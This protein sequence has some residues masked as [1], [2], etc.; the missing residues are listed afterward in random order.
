[1]RS[2]ANLPAGWLS[3]QADEEVPAGHVYHQ[4]L[5][6]PLATFNALVCQGVLSTHAL[7]ATSQNPSMTE[8]CQ[9]T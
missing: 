9:N 2:M 6:I 1:M 5:S 4:G 8:A 7:N 3:L